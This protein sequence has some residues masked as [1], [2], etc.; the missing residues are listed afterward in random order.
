MSVHRFSAHA[1]ILFI[2]DYMM[3][4]KTKFAHPR[5]IARI[6]HHFLWSKMNDAIWYIIFV[7]R[8]HLM[9][10]EGRMIYKIL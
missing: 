10:Y 9:L 7:R 5:H 4:I 6:I 8:S 2:H 1:L 3:R